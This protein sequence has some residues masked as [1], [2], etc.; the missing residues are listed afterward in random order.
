MDD[1]SMALIPAVGKRQGMWEDEGNLS[2]LVAGH[3]AY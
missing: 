1:C 3:P 2:H